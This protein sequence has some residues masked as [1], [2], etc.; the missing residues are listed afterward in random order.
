VVAGDAEIA[1]LP[2]TNPVANLTINFYRERNSH[3]H[4]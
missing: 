1:P 4:P 3:E 2:K